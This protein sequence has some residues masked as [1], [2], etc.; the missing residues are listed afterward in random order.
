MDISKNNKLTLLKKQINFVES[1]K[2][3][4]LI[5]LV[6]GGFLSF[7]VIFIEPFDTNDF[8]SNNRLFQLSVFGIL[9]FIVF[10]I[11]SLFE[12]IWY[13][14]NDDT[15]LVYNEI[16]S[17]FVF[18]LISGTIIYLY[19]HLI[20]NKLKYTIKSHWLYYK[21]IVSVMLPIFAPLF[22]YLRQQFGVKK[23]ALSSNYIR[24]KGEN[25]N[26]L[27][28]LQKEEL[29]FI[30]ATEN[31]IEISFLDSNQNLKT[32]TFRQTLTNMHHRFP[33]L[34]KCHR[35]YLVNFENIEEIQGSSQNAKIVL[36]NIDKKIPLS[37]TYYS[38]VRS[39]L[40]N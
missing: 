38:S 30:K 25:K 5:G 8:V 1:I 2:K 27:L 40:F 11:Q 13:H 39:R 7:I 4:F 20:I 21:N 35:S 15:W 10:L 23:N 22:I 36:K 33:F 19:N 26:E 18:F 6:L 31:Y 17:T 29:L 28:V 24:I 37:K 12:T 34:F 9:F 3:K 14:R 16:I 32:K